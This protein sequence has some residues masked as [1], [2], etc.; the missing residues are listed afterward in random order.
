MRT[1][2]RVY[3]G[4]LVGSM[5]LVA[6]LA[7]AG[8][9]LILNRD[10][11]LGRVMLIVIIAVLG[12]IFL[13]MGTGVM[14]IVVMLIRSKSI[15]SLDSFTRI[16]NEILFPITLITGRIAGIN[17]DKI[18]QSY[19]EV[20]NNLVKSKKLLLEGRQ[21]MILLPHCL[22][23][24]ECPHKITMDI[25]NCNQCGNCCIAELIE[26]GEKY[27]A[28]IKVATGGTLARKFIEE[29]RPR[30]VVA[31]ACERDLSMGIQD[32][33]YLP[34]IGVLNC[35]PNGPC[36]NTSVE[37]DKVEQAILTICKGE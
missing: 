21:V 4:L 34:V 6:L 3:V 30:G 18:L 33:S 8:W 35:R 29:S 9:Y 19:I 24:S 37:I 22:Q 7:A 1:K 14:A 28:N 10:F 12:A 15:P 17:K 16:A 31:V 11:I 36:I 23:N 2:K 25:N 13:L 32:A 26:L 20:N 27:Q 5:F